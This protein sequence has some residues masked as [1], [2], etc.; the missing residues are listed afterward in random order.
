MTRLRSKYFHHSP[1]LLIFKSPNNNNNNTTF[2][3]QN[4]KINTI[5]QILHSYCLL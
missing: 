3:A 4:D 5:I 1:Y 2:N